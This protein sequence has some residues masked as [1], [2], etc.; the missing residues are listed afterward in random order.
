MK[1]GVWILLCLFQSC[2]ST[3]KYQ[4]DLEELLNILTERS[5][6]DLTTED[7]DPNDRVNVELWNQLNQNDI[8]NMP[9]IDDYSSEITAKRWLKWYSRVSLRY[10]Q[11]NT[12]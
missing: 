9:E 6:D 1:I 8:E 5:Y 3:G 11:V 7:D 12:R 10:S 2:V 4:N